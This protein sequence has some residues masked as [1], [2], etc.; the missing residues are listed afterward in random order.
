MSGK[1]LKTRV[2]ISS[3]RKG[4]FDE[5]NKCISI[6]SIEGGSGELLAIHNVEFTK[7]W[8]KVLYGRK[9]AM[10]FFRLK[11][12]GKTKKFEALIYPLYMDKN[13]YIHCPVSYWREV[14][15]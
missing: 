11:G 3:N 15:N 10:A 8:N 2:F 6:P 4:P 9:N 1:L 12:S 14:R 13:C 5:L 7:S